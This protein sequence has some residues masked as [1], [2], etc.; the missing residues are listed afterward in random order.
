MVSL[1]LLS[2]P[3]LVIVIYQVLAIG[4]YLNHLYTYPF[5]EV[6]SPHLVETCSPR[7]YPLSD[8]THVGVLLTCTGRCLFDWV[9]NFGSYD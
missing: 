6:R 8:K 7:V 1:T 4:Y 9:L 3:A 2:I 5:Y